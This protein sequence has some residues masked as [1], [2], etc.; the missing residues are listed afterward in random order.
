MGRGQ[1]YCSTYYTAK[2][3]HMQQRI[4]WLKMPTATAVYPFLRKL[5]RSCKL[6]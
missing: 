3:S 2:D 1:N 4:I 5:Y 6:S